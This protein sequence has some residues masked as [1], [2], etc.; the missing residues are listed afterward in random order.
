M[1]IK[2]KQNNSNI[3]E[4][5]IMTIIFILIEN[6]FY[7]VNLDSI[8]I[9]GIFN[10]DDIPLVLSIVW[11][12]YVL[13]K[14]REVKVKKYIFK[15]EILF[16]F[17]LVILSSIRG[18]QLYGQSILLGMRAQRFFLIFF[19]MYFPLIKFI[20]ADERNRISIE[21]MIYGLGSLALLIYTT[22][23]FFSS[24]ILFLYVRESSRYGGT[25]LHFDSTLISLLFFLVI[26]KIFEGKKLKT[27]T[28]LMI[29]LII[30]NIF[31]IRGRLVILALL[32]SSIA[33]ILIWKKNLLI[34]IPVIIFGIIAFVFLLMTPLLSEYASILDTDVRNADQN[35]TIRQLGK[36][37][38]L[39]QLKDSP[40]TGRGYINEL[41]ERA[42]E[43]AGI[44]KGYYLNDNGIT[45]FVFMY[46][47]IGGAW[48]ISLFLKI[49]VY[50]FKMYIKQKKYV[51]IAYIIYLTTLLPNILQFYWGWGPIY[52]IIIICNL[53]IDIDKLRK[54][55]EIC[56]GAY[57]KN[58]FVCE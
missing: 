20:Y 36:E 52:T 37:N 34:K 24:K 19:L 55:E 13:I 21:K 47:V 26:Q 4:M 38:Y 5:I 45:A 39:S 14:Y 7:L 10:Y 22:Q 3:F 12:I 43:A 51:Y 9:R 46:G 56:D 2:S 53:E 31:I 54:N 30:Y 50:G 57:I 6:C 18:M 49:Y 41:N 33:I 1:I 25:R 32:V 17:I 40:I 23:Y 42:S 11:S 8:N 35:Y 15:Y 44:E 48:I 58:E 27:N 28:N 29:L 16:T